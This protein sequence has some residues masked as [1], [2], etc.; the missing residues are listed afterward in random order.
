MK[1]FRDSNDRLFI[2]CIECERG[3]YGNEDPCGSKKKGN[4]MLGCFN[5][6]LKEGYPVPPL[7]RPLQIQCNHCSKM[8]S[9]ERVLGSPKICPHCGGEFLK[10]MV[11]Q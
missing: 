4:K 7:N 6:F 2:Y 8:Y 3:P 10:E 1:S 11:V 9:W 5:G